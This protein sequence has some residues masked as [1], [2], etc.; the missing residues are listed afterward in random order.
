MVRLLEIILIVSLFM[1]TWCIY[2][3]CLLGIDNEFQSAQLSTWGYDIAYGNHVCVKMNINF[4]EWD[5][6]NVVRF[7][8]LSSTSH[9]RLHMQPTTFGIPL[10]TIQCSD[11][12]LMTSLY[13]ILL[14]ALFHS[15]SHSQCTCIKIQM[16]CC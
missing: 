6:D 15:M 4:S 12:A 10:S 13:N 5:V 11:K 3:Q 9:F 2:V 8:Y 14:P 16:K 1:T 7:H